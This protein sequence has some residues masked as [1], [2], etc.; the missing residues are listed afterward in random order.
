MTVSVTPPYIPNYRPGDTDPHIPLPLLDILESWRA[1]ALWQRTR[2]KIVAL[3]SEVS[4]Q[5]GRM[6]QGGK[7]RWWDT[8]NHKDIVPFG[9]GYQCN[10]G[11]GVLAELQRDC[12]EASFEFVNQGDVTVKSDSPLV[13]KS[14]IGKDLCRKASRTLR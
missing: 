10:K 12:R 3:M 6:K 11:F 2:E 9:M 4:L 1:Q 8:Q 13:I 7:I 5:A 14:P